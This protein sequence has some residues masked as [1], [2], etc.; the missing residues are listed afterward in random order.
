MDSFPILTF[1]NVIYYQVYSFIFLFFLF[2]PSSLAVV[3]FYH[4]V[5]CYVEYI[6]MQRKVLGLRQFLVLEGY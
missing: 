4:S 3:N 6:Y 5:K 2:L 1:K